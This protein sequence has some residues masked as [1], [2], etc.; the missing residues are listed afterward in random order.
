MLKKQKKNQ[1]FFWTPD[2]L[3]ASTSSSL[4]VTFNIFYL[5][6]SR[7]L[8]FGNNLGRTVIDV[9]PFFLLLLTMLLVLPLLLSSSSSSLML[10]LSYFWGGYGI[11]QYWSRKYHLHILLQWS[12]N[13][14]TL[15][16][17]HWKLRFFA[18]KKQHKADQWTDTTSSK[19][20]HMHAFMHLKVKS[21]FVTFDV[22]TSR[23]LFVPDIG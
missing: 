14:C 7:F 6:I 9:I 13:Y 21:N 3:D 1:T 15:T 17:E 23:D 20:A 16:S 8:S 22:S 5:Q 19:D 12:L 10:D 2:T 4:I 11:G 18:I